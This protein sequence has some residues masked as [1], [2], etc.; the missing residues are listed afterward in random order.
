ML[1]YVKSFFQKPE[2]PP[3]VEIDPVSKALPKLCE[4]LKSKDDYTRARA[5]CEL[6]KYDFWHSDLSFL[7][8]DLI[9]LLG[10]Q[11]LDIRYIG[12]KA[13]SVFLEK[14]SP[15]AD[16]LPAVLKKAFQDEH[17][18]V[19]SLQVLS[20]IINPFI[21][22]AIKT[23]L[24]E[25]ASTSTDIARKLSLY[26]IFNVY[27]QRNSA[28]LELI[29]LLKRS[30]F[31]TS[32][33]FSAIA[34][35]TEMAHIEPESM[36]LF[37]PL[38]IAE[39][40]LSTPVV[41]IKL[42]KFFICM[43]SVEENLQQELEKVLPNY[44]ASHNDLLSLMEAANLISAFPNPTQAT[45]VSQIAAQ[46]EALLSYDNNPNVKY[47][48]LQTLSKLYPKYK[49][50]YT[51]I[52]NAANSDYTHVSG[53][54]LTILHEMTTQKAQTLSEMIAHIQKTKDTD[55]AEH[56]L[57]ILP[58]KG[59]RFITILF[60]LY[61]LGM[62]SLS[63]KLADVILAITDNDTQQKLVRSVVDGLIETPDDDFGFAL[64]QAVGQWSTEPNDIEVLLPSSIGQ[65]TDRSKAML[66]SCAFEMWT[67]LQFEVPTVMMRRIELLAQSPVR[68][69]R[70]P[71]G[72]ML[73][74]IKA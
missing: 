8:F 32:L 41:F 70:I 21:Y 22:D 36:K 34:I 39:L 15:A 53:Q 71:A 62:N 45:L 58:K 2:Q 40:A 18:I 69:V 5:I 16:M 19:P 56:L 44:L 64:A 68:S 4:D 3:P 24:I 11:N 7:G 65:K 60:Q 12:L 66:I 59:Q 27:L 73:D 61:E 38:L 49:P 74:M 37:T 42:A 52:S 67:R 43:L 9:S 6:F 63:P 30:I 28:S 13:C 20:R 25:V 14:N 35:L 17:L 10:S 31:Q 55:L 33:R 29:P 72:E 51:T 57:Q 46:I 48:C 50:E 26:A 54:A 47:V 1:S 23:D